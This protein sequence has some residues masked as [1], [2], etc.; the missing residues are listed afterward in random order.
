MAKAAKSAGETMGAT[1]ETIETA[2]NTGTEALKV[3]FEKVVKNYDQM[4][5]YGKDTVEACVKSASVAG[6]GAETLHNEMYSYSKQSVEDF[7]HRREGAVR[8]QVDPGSVGAAKR[9]R[10]IRVRGLCRRDDEAL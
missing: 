4:V 1:A 5:G 3:G 6:K 7:D 8:H 10:E 2:M 9:L